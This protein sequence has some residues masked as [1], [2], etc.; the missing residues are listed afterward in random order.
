MFAAGCLTRPLFAVLGSALEEIGQ[1][2]EL[3][4]YMG[5]SVNVG[6]WDLVCGCRDG[7]VCVLVDGVCEKSVDLVA[8]SLLG[9]LMVSLDEARAMF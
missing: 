5:S 8:L 9:C 3:L 7:C 4:G 1:G 6:G 2:H